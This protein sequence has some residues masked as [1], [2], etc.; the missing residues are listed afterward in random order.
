M[1]LKQNK[2]D[3][4]PEKIP[5]IETGKPN[6]ADN[7]KIILERI[8][9][10]LKDCGYRQK[11]QQ[12]F[13][14]IQ[15]DI[16]AFFCAEHPSDTTYVWF[17]VKPLYIPPLPYLT[18]EPGYRLSYILHDDTMNIPDHAG[19]R[20]LYQ[21]CKKT[22]SFAVN[23]AGP[24][25]RD[26]D[27]ASKMVSFLDK[28]RSTSTNK[29][30]GLTPIMYWELLMYAELSLHHY[31][32]AE[33]AAREYLSHIDIPRYTDTVRE[34][35]RRDHMLVASLCRA[36]DDELTD[37]RVNVWRYENTRYFTGKR[38]KEADDRLSDELQG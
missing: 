32:D 35:G 34:K 12:F 27:T 23:K 4:G 11:G 14:V 22:S 21:W 19:K 7:R 28:I 30:T 10:C 36:N 1:F 8:A 15:G 25:I 38:E 2:N 37:R 6:L 17:C 24:F 18:L 33:K 13:Y 29:I 5:A 31:P 20:E 16:A 9:Q 26:I 3:R